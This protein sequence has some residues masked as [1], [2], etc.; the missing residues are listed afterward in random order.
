MANSYI[1]VSGSENIYVA[2]G[3]K[4][5]IDKTVTYNAS[6]KTITLNGYTGT[7]IKTNVAN[8]YLACSAGATAQKVT[9]S[10]GTSVNLAAADTISISKYCSTT[11]ATTTT[12][13]T[14]TTTTK[15]PETFDPILGYV[16]LAIFAVVALVSRKLYYAKRK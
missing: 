9:G 13:T 10:N 6:T 5:D 11:T 15:N 14:T 3:T 8:L 7:S 4:T 12:A 2:S 1:Q 16:A